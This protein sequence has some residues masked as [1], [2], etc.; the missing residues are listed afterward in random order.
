MANDWTPKKATAIF[1][2]II[3]ALQILGT[4]G[5]WVKP[6]V[7]NEQ[8]LQTLEGNKDKLIEMATANQQAHDIIK[9]DL[10][11][12]NGRLER[13]CGNVEILVNDRTKNQLSWENK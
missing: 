13:L 10:G 9:R 5:T 3:L 11:D 7:L 2:L 8:R 1:A 4:I 12:M 6:V